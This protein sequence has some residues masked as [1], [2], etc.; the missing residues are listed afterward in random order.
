[1]PSGQHREVAVAPMHQLPRRAMRE[2]VAIVAQHDARRPPRHQRVEPEL[3]PA[4]RQRRGIEQMALGEDAFLA[5]IE[6]RQ[7]LAVAQHRFEL[8]RRQ[9]G[10]R[11]GGRRAE[12]GIGPATRGG[13]IDALRQVLQAH[14]VK[15]KMQRR[16]AAGDL[17]GVEIIGQEGAG[18]AAPHREL[19][20]AADAAAARRGA[21]VG[22]LVEDVVLVAEDTGD[23][24]PGGVVVRRLRLAGNPGRGIERKAPVG[25]LGKAVDP[26]L[27]ARRDR[28]MLRRKQLG[29]AGKLDQHRLQGLQRGAGHAVPGLDAADALQRR[30]DRLA[31]LLHQRHAILPGVFRAS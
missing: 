17:D 15:V 13:E 3:E 22:A 2:P 23:H 5:D 20:G 10:R 6:D 26:P 11:D 28:E 12:D 1:M 31:A 19:A 25:I 14:A 29:A 16:R 8:G 4:Q 27:A 18:I 30:F 9:H 21:V 7:L 24:R